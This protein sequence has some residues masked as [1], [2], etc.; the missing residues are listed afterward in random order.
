MKTTLQ[1]TLT[2]KIA[3]ITNKIV[4]EASNLRLIDSYL[5]YLLN[6][7]MIL[8]GGNVINELPRNQNS[9]WSE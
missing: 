4:Y 5:N 3:F 7:F 6:S 8:L 1:F 2:E 9:I